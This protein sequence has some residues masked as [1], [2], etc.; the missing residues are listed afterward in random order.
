MHPNLADETR[1]RMRILE[2]R[3]YWPD[4]PK[5]PKMYRCP[6]CNHSTE[7]VEKARLHSLLCSKKTGTIWSRLNKLSKREMKEFVKKK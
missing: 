4:P 5:R 1:A 7:D 2:E 6:W 3:A